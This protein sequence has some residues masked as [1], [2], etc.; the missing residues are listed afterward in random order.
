M[1]RSHIC[2]WARAGERGVGGGEG[3]RERERER[4]V[5]W[6]GGANFGLS[7]LP[8]RSRCARLSWQRPAARR[9]SFVF[10]SKAS[11]SAH[12]SSLIHFAFKLRDQV[13]AHRKHLRTEKIDSSTRKSERQ[14]Q[15]D[16]AVPERRRRRRRLFFFSATTNDT[17]QSTKRKTLFFLRSLEAFRL[18]Q[19]AH[20][21][22]SGSLSK[23]SLEGTAGMIKS[24]S[25]TPSGEEE[26]I[27]V[28][29]DVRN[30]RELAEPFACSTWLRMKKAH[31]F[32]ESGGRGRLLGGCLELKSRWR[33]RRDELIRKIFSLLRAKSERV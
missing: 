6:T 4:E 1:T 8:S 15:D 21:R 10:R 11:V 5:S 29:L 23:S 18:V 16:A 3:G 31:A 22:T 19:R 17:V 24:S 20:R 33:A 14:A 9:T 12:I 26:A 30:Q 27:V 25:R 13:N 7:L 28:F 2:V 32:V